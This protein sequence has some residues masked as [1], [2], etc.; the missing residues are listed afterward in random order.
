MD[1]EFGKKMKVAINNLP[2][3]YTENVSQKK[4]TIGSTQHKLEKKMICIVPT[5]G[6]PKKNWYLLLDQ[7]LNFL[8]HIFLS[9]CV[10][11]FINGAEL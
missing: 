3:D 7:R 10:F 5:C 11:I 6:F 4:L 2:P 1:E 8:W 9:L